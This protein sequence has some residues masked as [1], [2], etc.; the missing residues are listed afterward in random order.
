MEIAIIQTEAA[1]FVKINICV[2]L[3]GFGHNCILCFIPSIAPCLCCSAI[4]HPYIYMYI[5]SVTPLD[6]C[7]LGSCSGIVRLLVILVDITGLSVLEA[8]AFRYN[9]INICLTM[10][11]WPIKYDL[12]W[13]GPYQST[14]S[15]MKTRD[16]TH[17]AYGD[18]H[19]LNMEF[20]L[21]IFDELVIESDYIW[22]LIQFRR[23]IGVDLIS[24]D[25]VLYCS[26][27][28]N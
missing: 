17:I 23:K 10:C 7:V 2:I 19:F 27:C 4:A 14:T 15:Y 18:L 12:I 21:W 25:A 20:D 3:K 6:L 9:H 26:L 16:N 1:D 24:L 22:S 13:C 8:Q 28:N 11:M 5:F